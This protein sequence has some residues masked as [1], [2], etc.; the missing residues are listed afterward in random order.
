MDKQS[1]S[2]IKTWEENAW[3]V[4][5]PWLCILEESK[6]KMWEEVVGSHMELLNAVL[7]FRCTKVYLKGR[8]QLLLRSVSILT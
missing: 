4:V 8:N 7:L 3:L 2:Q 1:S 5:T 6:G